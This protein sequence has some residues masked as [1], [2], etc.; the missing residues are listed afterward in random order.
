MAV[1]REWKCAHHGSF[2]SSHPICPNFGCESE[3]VER[4]FRTAV[5]IVSSG[6]RRFDNGIK[7][8]VDGM[9]LGNLR[10]AHRDGDSSYGGDKARELG[11]EI[12][13]GDEVKKRPEFRGMGF[14]ALTQQAQQPFSVQRRDGSVETL[15][16][17]NG[18]RQAANEVGI[19][20]RVLPKAER[21]IHKSDLKP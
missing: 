13:W 7:Q 5:S 16:D 14:D 1:L 2:E 6:R 17:N 12:L 9:R 21:S 18:M 20:K 3:A 4:E 19:T 10:T 8:T 11:T 15:T